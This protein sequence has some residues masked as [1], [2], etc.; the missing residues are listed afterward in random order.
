MISELTPKEK[1]LLQE[2]RKKK[3]ELIAEI[4]VLSYCSFLI[5]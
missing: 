3:Q 5:Y 4:Q 1:Q 2:I